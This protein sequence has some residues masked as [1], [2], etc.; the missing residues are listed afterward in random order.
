MATKLEKQPK[1]KKVK[2]PSKPGR[3]AQIRQSY[4]MTKKSDPKIGLILLGTFLLAGLAGFALM[5]LI[6]RTLWFP[7]LIGV[8]V[9]L[10]AVLV[11]F[12]RRAATAAY[13]QIEGRPGAAAAALQQLRRGW[14]TDPAVAVNK[15]QDIVT[16][17]VGR[18]GIVLIGEG[19]PTR[20]K[21]LLASERRRHER[22]AREV[23]IH[24]LVVGREPGQ[25]P[26]PKL[27]K[28]VQKLGKEV[29]PAQLTD[30]LARIKAID[31]HRSAVP[32]PKGPIPTSMKGQRGNLRGR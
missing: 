22:V 28:T 25:V 29:K 16:R 7:I 26:L 17:V 11:V 2:D 14:K 12:G 18:P 5:L 21:G 24:E 8:L 19:N 23:P 27:T 1:A 31:A 4:T 10:F 13:K 9:G 15:Q 30:V 20:L 3:I 6:F 32:M